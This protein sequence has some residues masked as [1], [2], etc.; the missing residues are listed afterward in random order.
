LSRA[1]SRCPFSDSKRAKAVADRSSQPSADC[2]RATA[3]DCIRQSAADVRSDR[4]IAARICPLIR[5]SSAMSNVAPQLVAPCDG[6]VDGD[7]RLV[8]LPS[9][10]QAFRQRALE[11]RGQDVV[12][13]GV[14]RLQRVRSK[15]R[16]VPAWSRVTASSPFSAIPTA[17]YGASEYRPAYLINRSMESRG[18]AQVAPPEKDRCR[19]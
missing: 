1:W 19:I 11:N 8:E 7:Q 13:F 3:S 17:R 10:P 16:P 14:Q 12:L 18:S 4:G 15:I 6:S 2:S 5:S 9:L